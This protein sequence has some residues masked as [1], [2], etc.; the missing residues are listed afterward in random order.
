MRLKFKEKFSGPRK[1]TSTRGKII[2]R[3]VLPMLP[4]WISVL[5]KISLIQEICS[6]PNHSC[7]LGRHSFCFKNEKSKYY[8]IT[9]VDHKSWSLWKST[10]VSKNY[11]ATKTTNNFSSETQL[12]KAKGEK[13]LGNL[14]RKQEFKENEDF[15]SLS[16]RNFQ[17]T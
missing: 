12:L 1:V 11:Q 15:V 9:P 5:R 13:K 16:C 7:G 6:Q 4:A 2:L 10:H 8:Y 17:R 14:W 3:F